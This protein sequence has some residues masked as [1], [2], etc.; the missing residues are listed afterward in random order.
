MGSNES[1]NG[2][3]LY[4]DPQ[5][6][7]LIASLCD[8]YDTKHGLAVVTGPDQSGL[9]TIMKSLAL[10]LRQDK[11]AIGEVN[12]A[13]LDVSKTTVAGLLVELLSAFG[14][15]LP[16]ATQTE[17]L[18]MTLL[19]AQHQAQ[20]GLS[21]LV[22]LEHVDKA[23]P[24]TLNIINQLA[25]LRHARRSA[26]SLVLTGG[27]PLNHIVTAEAMRDV[28]KRI[29]LQT[30]LSPFT[31]DERKDFVRVLLSNAGV[32]LPD[33]SINSLARLGDG[34]PGTMI[35]EIREAITQRRPSKALGSADTLDTLNRELGHSAA[36]AAETEMLE[37]TT[38]IR[39]G[40][41]SIPEVSLEAKRIQ[42]PSSGAALGEFLI[43][44]NG[45]LVERFPITRRK[46]LIGRAQHNDIVLNSKWVSRYHAIIVCHRT[47]ASLVDINSTNGMT[48]NS[49]LMRQGELMHNDVV[50]V[51]DY[52]IKYLNPA[53]K[54]RDTD[55]DLSETRV[56]KKIE[57]PDYDLT[58]PIDNA[59]KD[60]P[61]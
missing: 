24:A 3:H 55:E 61:S 32:S 6:E 36:L 15:D 45:Q 37:D 13:I 38:I 43:N 28:G 20:S 19:I 7:E 53:A 22:I 25:A 59:K 52:R 31:I 49:T 33:R 60:R 9:T 16:N 4:V 30:H 40:D 26:C 2:Q 12:V 1:A 39:S 48:V 27:E 46:V 23:G 21:P 41:L 44:H 11:K 57:A 58:I 8:V 56:L 18:S 35:A 42:T 34:W 29:S 51:G 5:R 10:R 47:G 17:L 50:V 54:N 14:Y